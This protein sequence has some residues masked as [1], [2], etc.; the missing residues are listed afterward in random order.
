MAWSLSVS[1][2]AVN[3][4]DKNADKSLGWE[5]ALR[6]ARAMLFQANLKRNQLKKAI[7]IIEKKIEAGEPWPGTTQ[8]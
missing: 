5:G 4:K 1:G 8:N 2:K 7:E 6:D 3:Q